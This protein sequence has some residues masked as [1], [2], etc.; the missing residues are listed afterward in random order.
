MGRLVGKHPEA[1]E[2]AIT[3]EKTAL[4][5]GAKFTW[6]RSETLEELSKPERIASIKADHQKAVERAERRK[7]ENPLRPQSAQVDLDDIYGGGKGCVICHK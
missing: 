7:V 2:E 5:H 1:F 4:D 3:Y 6:C